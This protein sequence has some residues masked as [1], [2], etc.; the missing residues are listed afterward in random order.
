MVMKY[1]LGIKKL[2]RFWR[3]LSRYGI[4]RWLRANWQGFQIY[5]RYKHLAKQN[6]ASHSRAILVIDGPLL[7]PDDSTMG[8]SYAQQLTLLQCMGLRLFLLLDANS[9]DGSVEPLQNVQWDEPY[10]VALRKQGVPVLAGFFFRRHC[11]QWL[12]TNAAYFDYILFR[13]PEQAQVYGELVRT[14]SSAKL[15]LLFADL[16]T[17]RLQLQY[18]LTGDPTVLQAVQK[19]SG[20]E[21]QVC[22]QVD[23]LLTYSQTEANWLHQQYGDKVFTLP[24]FIYEQLALPRVAAPAHPQLLFVGNLSHPPNHDGLD[25][26]VR[27]CLPLLFQHCPAVKL[28]VVGVL[29]SLESLHLPAA[30]I[31]VLGKVTD[32]ELAICYQ[33][34]RVV[35]AP[36]RFGAGVKGKVIEALAHGVPV[37]TTSFGV[38][39]VPGLAEVVPP[40]DTPAAMVMA[41][42]HLLSDDADWQRVSLAGQA[43]VRQHFSV[44]AAQASLEKVFTWLEANG[45]D[46][47]T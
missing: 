23:A 16:P 42:R 12:Q 27:E 35:I 15:L 26:F 24:I 8:R 5:R 44:L 17:I 21:A 1:Y 13:W 19:F 38:E 31:T 6:S 18:N 41:I 20:L 46:D 43:F 29:W 9:W 33:Q 37:V 32:A 36:L 47:L 10:A 40:V 7:R 39:G 4:R 22:Q 11:R 30:Q 34:A 3:Q 28:Q 25:W 14:H 45:S 2:V